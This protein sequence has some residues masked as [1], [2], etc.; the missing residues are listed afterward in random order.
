LIYVTLGAIFR[1]LSGWVALLAGRFS[2]TDVF[3]VGF[4]LG[5]GER[6]S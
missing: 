2:G 5:L 3:L 6:S 4:F 1:T